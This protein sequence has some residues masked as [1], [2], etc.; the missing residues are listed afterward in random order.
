MNSPL[1]KR[2]KRIATIQVE[3]GQVVTFVTGIEMKDATG[4]GQDPRDKI[5][6]LFGFKTSAFREGNP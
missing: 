6:H 2:I 4:R 3:P 1:I 5:S